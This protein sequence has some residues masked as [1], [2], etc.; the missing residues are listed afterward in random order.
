MHHGKCSV[1]NTLLS[2]E[3]F[4]GSLNKKYCNIHIALFKNYY[5]LHNKSVFDLGPIAIKNIDK[6]YPSNLQ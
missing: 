1:F 2:F 6:K 4:L 3:F 5:I